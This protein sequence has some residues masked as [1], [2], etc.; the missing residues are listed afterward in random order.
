MPNPERERCRAQIQRRGL[1]L[2]AFNNAPQLIYVVQGRGIR[3]AV[4]PGCPE[5]YQSGSEQS[6]SQLDRQQSYNDQ[7]QRIRQIKEGEVIALRAGVAHWI[8]TMGNPRSFWS[9]LLTLPMRPTSLI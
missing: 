7:H 9:H 8:T 1:L 2:P 3:G 4:F 5:T 6:Q